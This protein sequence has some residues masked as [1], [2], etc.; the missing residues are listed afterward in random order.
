MP[1]PQELTF[2][3]LLTVLHHCFTTT[4]GFV[5]LCGF[6]LVA[7]ATFRYVSSAR[8]AV[9]RPK[10]LRQFRVGQKVNEAKSLAE[11]VAETEAKLAALR[12]AK[13]GAEPEPA[14]KKDA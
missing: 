4:E 8:P 7:C 10:R 6:L 1:R 14:W 12:E 11:Q 5:Q 3:E 9:S 2:S 13:T